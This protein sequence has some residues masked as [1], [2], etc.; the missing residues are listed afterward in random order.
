MNTARVRLAAL[1]VLT[2]SGL[3]LVA[4]QPVPGTVRPASF[5]APDFNVPAA[6]L[7]V[8][9]D[10]TLAEHAFLLGEA[11]RSGLTMGPDFD[12]VGNALEANTVD[13]VDLVADVYGSDAG[14]AFGDLWRSH[15][16]Y[17]IDY[18]RAL[19]TDDVEARELAEHQL[20]SYVEDF[21]AFL[22]GANPNLPRD[23]VD[24]LVSEHIQQLE[25]IAA[26]DAGD[27]DKAYPA[28][29]NTYNHMFKIG[30]AL[31]EGIALQFPELFTGKS[32]AY[33]PAG[34]LR[35]ALDQ[36]LGEHTTLAVTAM[37]A[38]VTD[39]A[40]E[41]AAR[42]ALDGNT[43]AL[44]AWVT[45]VYG[46]AAG[47]AFGNL[48]STHTTAYLAYVVATTNAD[49]AGRQQAL[50]QLD[51]YS[52]DFS[53]FMADANPK[54]SASALQGM[55]DHHT[56]LLIAEADAY[57]AGDYQEAYDLARES[58]EHSITMADALALAI[59]AQF[60]D[61]FPDASMPDRSDQPVTWLGIVLLIAALVSVRLRRA[62]RPECT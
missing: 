27:Y 5:A 24:E 22:S 45:D 29:H 52:T 1:V 48:W 42:A 17:L 19:A 46:K 53:Q 49:E 20:H 35:I 34:D 55:L 10:T 16:A 51:A 28:L 15:V 11:M 60:P 32:L 39:A 50:S 23:V 13:L 21:S 59:A 47:Q 6:K 44:A 37:R 57:A 26:F 41:A 12:A 56:R 9:L 36:L 3:G 4:A 58:F 38:G 40:D 54:L 31:A 25:G 30:D 2:L 43:D 7:R 62:V 33:S 61:M 14:S 8:S 18:T